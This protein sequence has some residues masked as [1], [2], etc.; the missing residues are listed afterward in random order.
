MCKNLFASAKS[1]IDC[2][3][4]V[5]P[6]C[7]PKAH[8]DVFVDAKFHAIVLCCSTCDRPISIIHPR[9]EEAKKK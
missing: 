5:Y 2:P 8:L 3:V 6:K 1:K 9:E 4:R 7:H